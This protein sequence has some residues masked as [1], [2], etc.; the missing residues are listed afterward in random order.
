MP[1]PN[2]QTYYF[3]A[4]LDRWIFARVRNQKNALAKRTMNERNKST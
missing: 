2:Y 1:N 3:A 4:Y